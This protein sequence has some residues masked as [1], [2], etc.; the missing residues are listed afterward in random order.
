MKPCYK[1][2]CFSSADILPCLKHPSQL[3]GTGQI[4]HPL[5][6]VVPLVSIIIIKKR[7]YILPLNYPPIYIFTSKVSNVT[8]NLLQTFK[9]LQFDHFDFFFLPKCPNH[10]FYFL[11]KKNPKKIKKPKPKRNMPPSHIC[12]VNLLFFFFFKKKK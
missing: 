1:G 11:E 4:W 8:L 3:V 12:I 2:F 7:N 5:N 9:L 10:I 6:T